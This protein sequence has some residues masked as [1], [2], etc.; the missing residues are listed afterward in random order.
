M[1]KS[2][3]NKTIDLTVEEGRQYLQQCMRAES[4]S[5]AAPA[6]AAVSAALLQSITDRVNALKKAGIL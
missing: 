6:D 3:R 1:K 5:A 2:E 4:L